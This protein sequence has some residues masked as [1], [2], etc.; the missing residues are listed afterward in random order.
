MRDTGYRRCLVALALFVGPFAVQAEDTLDTVMAR[1]TADTAVQISYRE[2][3]HQE[4]LAEPWQGSGFFYAQPPTRL[5]K[6]EL[7]PSRKIMAIHGK[8]MWYYDADNEIRHNAVMGNRRTAGFPVAIFRA[9]VNGDQQHLE[10]SYRIEFITS[11][12]QWQILLTPKTAKDLRKL[13]QIFVSGPRE[14]MAEKIVVH[15]V[16]GDRDEFQLRKIA[17]GN[18]LNAAIATLFREAEGD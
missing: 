1:M 16:D 17:E 10:Q 8:N 9:L 7:T 3:R 15:H 4:L 5:I 14:G 13:P 2:T 11:P 18:E 6:L 12:Q